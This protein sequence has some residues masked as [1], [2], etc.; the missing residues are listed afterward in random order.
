MNDVERA[1]CSRVARVREDVGCPQEAFAYEL[2][3]S[4]NKLAAI[5]YG[6]TP[7]RYQ[8]ARR[9]C[10]QFGVNL[11][12]LASELGAMKPA[13]PIDDGL[14]KIIPPKALLSEAFSRFIQKHIR[15]NDLL[16]LQDKANP[17]DADMSP[18]IGLAND[19]FREWYTLREVRRAMKRLPVALRLEFAGY[20]SE[21]IEDFGLS[22]GLDLGQG[23]EFHPD[24]KQIL[25]A[26][27]KQALTKVI[28]SGNNTD[29]K[30]TMA[31]LLARLNKATKAH[32]M[33]SKL[34]KYMGAPLPNVSQW[35][36]GERE[37][38]GE[39]TLRLLNW[40]EQQERK[41]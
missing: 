18:P 20:L 3:I 10:R 9:L 30:L 28:S 16:A 14:D 17:F 33:K 5:E 12:W 15:T 19:Q 11:L 22:K 35:L 31:T 6:T 4:R 21:R 7:L 37:P 25:A 26:G 38:S 41:Q 40:V 36:S 8:L 29:V 1:I 24:K 34:A 27:K 32:G 13:V 2:D 39:T 23:L